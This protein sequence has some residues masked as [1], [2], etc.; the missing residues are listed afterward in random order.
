MVLPLLKMPMPPVFDIVMVPELVMVPVLKMPSAVTDIVMLPE[1]VMVPSLMMPSPAGLFDIVM[2]PVAE[3]V[4]VPPERLS[5]PI[6]AKA[7]F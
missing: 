1:L 6:L 4:M 7:E 5:M 2:M 3:L